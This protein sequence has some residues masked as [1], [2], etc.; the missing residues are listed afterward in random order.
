LLEQNPEPDI[1]IVTEVK[2]KKV[3][4]KIQPVE[5]NMEGY[6]SFS[7]DFE[8]EGSR[9]I[10]VYVRLSL[11]ADQKYI[12]TQY[13]EAVFVEVKGDSKRENVNIAAIYRSPNS[14]EKNDALLCELVDE[15]CKAGGKKILVGDFNYGQIIWRNKYANTADAKAAVFVDCIRRNG[16]IQ[17]VNRPT[18]YRESQEAHI[19]DLIISDDEYIDNITHMSPLG[20][21]DHVVL[22]FE[23]EAEYG[24]MQVGHKLNLNKGNYDGLREFVQECWNEDK[25]ECCEDTEQLW[26]KIKGALEEG[27]K[28]Y[29]P[30]VTNWRKKSSWTHP[31]NAGLRSMIRRKHRL[32]NRMRETE[33]EEIKSKYKIQ[34]NKVREASRIYEKRVQKE[35]SEQ[36][37]GNPKK[38]WRYVKSKTT[39]ISKVP[40]LKSRDPTGMEVMVSDDEKKADL[41][42]DQFSKVFTVETDDVPQMEDKHCKVKMEGLTITEEDVL[43]KLEKIQVNKSPGPDQIYPRVLMEVREQLVKPLTALFNKSIKTGQLPEDW[44]SADITALYKKGVKMMLAIT[45]R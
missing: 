38:I 37:K 6:A 40:D 30:K 16:L 34:N 35:V 45:G 29:V 33:N 28:K 31:V 3:R 7:S 26:A 42:A 21:S 18:R 1:V 27:I 15:F 9:G 44:L 43:K 8:Q 10:M 36:C 4:Y 2:P 12:G 20:K 17:H 39:T 22:K 23:C 41:L 11:I 5:L 25:L 32:W 14:S 13:N 24:E 19:L